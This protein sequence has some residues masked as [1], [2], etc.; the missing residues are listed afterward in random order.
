MRKL[1]IICGPTAVGKT[2]LAVHLAKKFNGELISADSRQVYK[3]LDIGTGKD[4]P[5]G[6]KFRVS[7]SDLGLNDLNLGFYNVGK[8]KVWGYD[9][10]KPEENFSVFK[11]V[12]FAKK[13]ILDIWRRGKLPIL[14]GG[15]GFYIK[16]LIDGIDTLNIP[17]N[18]HLREK[19]KG[20]SVYELSWILEKFDPEKLINMNA[21]DRK[22]PRRLLRAIEVA[23]YKKEKN[24]ILKTHPFRIDEKDILF[25]GISAPS[26]YLNKRIEQRVDERLSLGIENEIANLL[27]RGLRWDSQAMQS[28]GYRQWKVYFERH[29]GYLGELDSFEVNA[30]NTE[31]MKQNLIERWKRAEIQYAKRQMTWFKKDKRIKWFDISKSNWIECVENF[32]NKWHNKVD[33]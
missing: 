17:K 3:G 15:T 21:S 27:K 30:K 20:R 5:K 1:L 24:K 12:K 8:V 2:S 32:I 33:N 14:V 10:V 13:I 23:V 26:G 16:G 29:S 31:S 19:L 6:S 22:N 28:L 7:K 25:V 9:L 18:E 11:Y 4:L